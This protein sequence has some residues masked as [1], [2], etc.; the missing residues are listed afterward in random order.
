M[1]LLFPGV[2]PALF[3]NHFT[4]KEQNLLS[5]KVRGELGSRREPL[6]SFL[7]HKGPFKIKNIDKFAEEESDLRW[8]TLGGNFLVWDNLMNHRPPPPPPSP[9]FL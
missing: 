3:L 8:V 2:F 1:F 4:E 9:S 7:G 5:F 6:Q